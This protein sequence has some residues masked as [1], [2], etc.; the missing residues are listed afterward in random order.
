MRFKR[1]WISPNFST[2]E[3]DSLTEIIL[4]MNPNAIETEARDQPDILHISTKDD[5]S[6]HLNSNF[7]FVSD[8]LLYEI[9]DCLIPSM[10]YLDNGRQYVSLCLENQYITSTGFDPSTTKKIASM[11]Y[12]LGGY[13]SSKFSNDVTLVIA[14]TSLSNKAF[15]AKKNNIRMVKYD[16]IVQ[17]YEKCQ[18]IPC[19]RYTIPTFYGCKF[20][21]TDLMSK[22]NHELAKIIRENGGEWSD[23][24]ESNTTFLIANSISNST[25]MQVALNQGFPV[26][27]PDWVYQSRIKTTSPLRYTLNWWF[28]SNEKSNLFQD[29]S[30]SI[31]K[32]VP[33][34]KM[35]I[36]AII[37][38]NGTYSDTP[39]F[40][41]VNHNFDFKDEEPPKASIIATVRWLFACISNK[42]IYDTSD[43]I[44]FSPYSFK[45]IPEV[46]GQTYALVKVNEN[47][48]I[49]FADLLRSLGVTVFFKFSKNATMIISEY[50]DSSLVNRA[51]EYSIPVVTTKWLL[52]LI[53]T[54]V[55]PS[56]EKYRP[57]AELLSTNIHSLCK[58]LKRECAH[59]AENRLEC[60][61]ENSNYNIHD[62]EL[63]SQSPSQQKKKKRETLIGYEIPDLKFKIPLNSGVDPLLAVFGA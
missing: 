35:I 12:L 53:K 37:A 13:F 6:S 9:S 7:T 15:L 39:T 30:F 20:T 49:E 4:Q 55:M 8:S 48:R 17:C 52:Q 59:K 60:N 34:T 57:N 18:E 58:Q 26:I 14:A 3:R 63:F 41:I 1:F 27:K 50:P 25:K 28:L 11:V 40:F 5:V 61:T 45:E 47:R 43:S 46:K 2:S 38:H 54:G 23:K 36:D 19:E 16:W 62:L 29:L 31:S 44:T 24:F 21:S 32:N 22:Q 42:K 51:D 33:N 56:V 10:K